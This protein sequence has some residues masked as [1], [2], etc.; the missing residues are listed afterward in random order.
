MGI[1][2]GTNCAPLV[3]CFRFDALTE[4]GT[5]MRT[6][7]SGCKSDALP[8]VCVYVEG[9]GGVGGGGGTCSLVPLKY[10]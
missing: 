8:G 5:F 7:F 10:F 1:P 3:L 2:L 6:E 9:G 4:L